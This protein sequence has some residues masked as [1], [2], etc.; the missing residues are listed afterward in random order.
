ML[1][2][3][4][5][6]VAEGGGVWCSLFWTVAS[7]AD[8]ASKT[9]ESGVKVGCFTSDATVEIRHPYQY[10]LVSRDKPVSVNECLI[11]VDPQ[12]ST[13]VRTGREWILILHAS[14]ERDFV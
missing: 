11:E 6:G 5:S 4:G 10:L 2:L 1:S 7:R 12:H 3:F 13:A 14:R 9:C 8:S